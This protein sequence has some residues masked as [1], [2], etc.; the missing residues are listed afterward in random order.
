MRSVGGALAVTLALTS[1]LLAAQTPPAQTPA[2]TPAAPQ[3]LQ[4]TAGLTGTVVRSDLSTP[5][6]GAQIVAARVGGPIAEYKT[7]TTDAGGRF[8]L[9]ELAAGSYRIYAD[10]ENYLRAEFGRRLAGA[11]GVAVSVV[12]AQTGAPIVITMTPPGVIAGRVL[13]HGRPARQVVVRAHK[14]SFIDGTRYLNVVAWA[15]TDDRGEFRLFGLAPGSYVVSA[16]PFGHAR[17]AGDTLATPVIPSIA[18]GNTNRAVVP[19]SPETLDPAALDDAVYLAAFHPGTTDPTAALPIDVRAGDV[20]SGIT[21][22]IARARPFKVTGRVAG[23]PAGVGAAIRV[24]VSSRDSSQS[25]VASVESTDGVF[26]LTG[27]PPGRYVLT[28]QTQ[29]GQAGAA[30]V[31]ASTSIEVIDR[32]L[33]DIALTLVASVTVTGKVTV[34]GRAPTAAD[35]NIGVQLTALQGSGGGSALRI[36]PDG[37]F[38]ISGVIPGEFRFRTLNALGH[39]MWIKAAHFGADDVTNAPL[40]IDGEPRGRQLE[41]ALSSSMAVVDVTVQ[42]ANGRPVSGALVVAVPDAARRTR[43]SLY[44]SGTTDANGQLHLADLAPGEYKLFATGDIEAGAWQDPEVLR[45]YET[46][47]QIVRLAEGG[48]Q[49]LIMRI[50]R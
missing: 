16:T 27:V 29:P 21:V 30:R 25:S 15:Q 41:I 37:T 23:A 3:I 36:Q 31:A 33:G 11:T 7:T 42:D 18:N 13:D 12:D 8:A 19:L 34:D 24:G 39:A 46:R 1:A 50:L 5:I 45:V 40:R 20:V 22:S 49:A 6:A 48:T 28:A 35:G 9:R 2:P 17:I 43:S 14:P 10:H 26:E 38:A 47:G 44:K 32:D 4:H